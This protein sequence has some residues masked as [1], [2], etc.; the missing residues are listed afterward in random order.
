MGLAPKKGQKMDAMI[1]GM[2]EDGYTAATEVLTGSAADEGRA[3]RIVNAADLLACGYVDD[4]DID[5]RAEFVIARA[6]QI[7]A[8]AGVRLPDRASAF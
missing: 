3:W 7:C 5:A 1:E 8:G 2:I 6:A 4:V